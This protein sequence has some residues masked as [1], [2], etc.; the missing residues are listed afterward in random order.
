[1]L[2]RLFTAGEGSGR[3]ETLDQAAQVGLGQVDRRV[4]RISNGEYTVRW[5]NLSGLAGPN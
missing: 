3:E 1:M 2:R 5:T 4:G